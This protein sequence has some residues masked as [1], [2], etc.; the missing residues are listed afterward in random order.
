MTIRIILKSMQK[1][2]N[3]SGGTTTELFIYP[4]D[5]SYERREFLFRIST[6]LCTQ[7]ESTFTNLPGTRRILMPLDGNLRLRHEGRPPVDLAPGMCDV[8]SGEETTC[9][10]GSCRDFNLMLRGAAQGSMSYKRL[11]AGERMFI[12]APAFT[13]LY[14]WKGEVVLKDTAAASRPLSMQA[15]DFALLAYGTDAADNSSC[16]VCITAEMDAVLAAVYIWGI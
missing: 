11:R 14:L 5:A 16:S 13:G 6:A 7:A 12:S 1:T 2:A 3:W 8:F 4:P 15:G 10:Y 9:S